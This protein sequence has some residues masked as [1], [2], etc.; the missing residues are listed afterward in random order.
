MKFC[1]CPQYGAAWGPLLEVFCFLLSCV[2]QRVPV[3]GPQ[4]VIITTNRT[5]SDVRARPLAWVNEHRFT[6][7]ERNWVTLIAVTAVSALGDF[8]G[9]ASGGLYYYSYPRGSVLNIGNSW[10]IKT[11]FPWNLQKFGPSEGCR[12]MPLCGEQVCQRN[13][14]LTSFQRVRYTVAGLYQILFSLESAIK[15]LKPKSPTRIPMRSSQVESAGYRPVSSVTWVVQNPHSLNCHLGNLKVKI[16][17]SDLY[18]FI[19][20]LW[21]RSRIF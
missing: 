15:C 17:F 5:P 20:C 12:F 4:F 14:V 13:K 2:K 3:W 21:H 10:I 7:P 8:R 16:F 11:H 19:F 1:I 6:C 18:Y 9:A